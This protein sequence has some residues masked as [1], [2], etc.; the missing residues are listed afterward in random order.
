MDELEAMDLEDGDKDNK[1]KHQ[2]YNEPTSTA[3][4][5]PGNDTAADAAEVRKLLEE[6]NFGVTA[7]NVDRMFGFMHYCC[8]PCVCDT[9]DYFWVD[10]KTVKTRS[11]VERGLP[12]TKRWFVVLDSPC[13][14]PEELH[15]P[16]YQ[17]FDGRQTTLARDAAE[18]RCASDGHLEGATLSD[19]GYIIYGAFFDARPVTPN[20]EKALARQNE[21]PQHRAQLQPGR[22]S[23]DVS[24]LKT[25]KK[26]QDEVEWA[27]HCQ[28]R[29]DNG[30]N[31]GMGEIFR[32]VAQISTVQ[33]TE[34]TRMHMRARNVIVARRRRALLESSQEE[35]ADAQRALQIEDAPEGEG[36]DAACTTSVTPGGKIVNVGDCKKSATEAAG[37]TP[38]PP[39]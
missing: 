2:A 9:Q 13:N 11:D 5:V 28:N 24:G 16:F 39:L 33:E 25:N 37:I 8:W 19:N 6:A 3:L 30:Y 18:V 1:Q 34:T 31:S 27:G 14:R 32:K 29:A 12:G 38:A 23:F 7:P 17:P 4:A 10:S 15:K 21:D 20:E 26:F 22:T 36:E 35:S